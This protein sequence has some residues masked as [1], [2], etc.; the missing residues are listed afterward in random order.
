MQVSVNASTGG[1]RDNM[2]TVIP[3]QGFINILVGA[4][5]ILVIVIL[6]SYIVYSKIRSNVS[7]CYIYHVG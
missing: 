1:F 7:L 5:L 4:A 6:V 2:G 3:E